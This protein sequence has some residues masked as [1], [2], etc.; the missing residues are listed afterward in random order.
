MISLTQIWVAIP[1]SQ[2]R[3]INLICILNLIYV[4]SFIHF[5]AKILLLSIVF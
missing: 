2:G 5:C 3:E 1:S 4:L